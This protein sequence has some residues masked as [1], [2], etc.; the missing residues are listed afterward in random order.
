MKRVTP[1]QSP[2]SHATSAQCAI[3]RDGIN[4]IFRTCGNEL[5][6]EEDLRKVV[7]I[8]Q[9]NGF[10]DLYGVCVAKVAGH[11]AGAVIKLDHEKGFLEAA[12]PSLAKFVRNGPK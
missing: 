5:P 4:G 10:A 6:P 7:F 8:C 9:V 1:E 3:A 12:Y 2:H 11:R